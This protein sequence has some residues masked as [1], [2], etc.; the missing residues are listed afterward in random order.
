MLLLLFLLM[1]MC[2]GGASGG[3]APL[4]RGAHFLADGFEGM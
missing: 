4:Y 1:L 2:L 3:S